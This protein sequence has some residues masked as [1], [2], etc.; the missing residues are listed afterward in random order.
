MFLSVCFVL[1]CFLLVFLYFPV[2]GYVICDHMRALHVYLSALNGSCPLKGIP[3]TSYEDFL[4]GRCRDCNAFGGKCP[5]I[6]EK[7][8]T[9]DNL[10]HFCHLFN[11]FHFIS[12][13]VLRFIKK[14]R[15]NCI[16]AA[17]R[18]EAFP[19]DVLL[20]TILW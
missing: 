19:L 1:F 3:C 18:T 6:A 13:I 5:T 7:L 8:S 15:D 4:Q 20:P 2:Y 12:F 16:S 9:L 10:T 11:H 17:Q 14:Q